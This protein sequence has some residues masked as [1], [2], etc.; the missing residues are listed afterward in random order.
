MSINKN[1]FKKNLIWVVP[2]IVFIFSLMVGRY[3]INVKDLFKAIFSKVFNKSIAIPDVINTVIFN[4][5]LPRIIIAMIVGASLSLSGA[6]FQG[7]FRNPMVSP[8]ILGASQGAA[9]GA[10]LAIL[11]NLGVIQIQLFSF[12]FGLIAVFLTYFI[13]RKVSKNRDMALILILTGMMIGTLFNALV[14]LSKYVADPLNKLPT[15]TFWLM[16]SLSSVSSKDIFLVLIPFLIGAI[17]L[18]LLRWKL[19]LLAFGEEESIALG[20]NTDRMRFIVVISS[21]LMTSAAVSVCGLIGWVGLVVPHIS[22]LLVGPDL[23]KLMPM[24]IIVGSTYL[25]L[26]DDL[27][28]SIL[29]IEIPLGILTSIIGA[30]FFIYLLMYAR[31]GWS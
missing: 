19:N 14:S 6:A 24:S 11:L 22:R 26:V 30:P 3:F 23:K 13:S 7:M 25:L 31:R 1:N 12:V 27:A 15:I 4:I 16:G 9:F 2:I 10:A 20:L 28:R 21:T 18:L 5:R 17:P 8:D 29:P